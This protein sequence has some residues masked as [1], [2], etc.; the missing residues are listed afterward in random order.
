MNASQS[1]QLK[2]FSWTLTRARSSSRRLRSWI[3]LIWITIKALTQIRLRPNM[4]PQMLTT[5]GSLWSPCTTPCLIRL[6]DCHLIWTHPRLHSTIKT[7]KIHPSLSEKLLCSN[8]LKF[9]GKSSSRIRRSHAFLSTIEKEEVNLSIFQR[10]SVL[11]RLSL[12]T[13]P[14]INNKWEISNTIR[15]ALLMKECR[16]SWNSFPS[17]RMMRHSLIG[18]SKSIPIW[19]NFKERD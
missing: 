8:T 19:P 2:V 15:F 13:S 6:T 3:I 14:E 1:A 17:S 4:T 7:R 16:R 12:K 11:Q 10:K 5:R 9:G 18:E